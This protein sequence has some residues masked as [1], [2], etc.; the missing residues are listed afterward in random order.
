MVT[1]LLQEEDTGNEQKSSTIQRWTGAGKAN[2]PQLL[3]DRGQGSLKRKEDF[4]LKT[5][6]KGRLLVLLAE[7]LASFQQG[8]G[9]E[10]QQEN[11]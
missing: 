10:L 5:S 1:F 4:C 7:A 2:R 9:R 11:G 3:R 6:R 8:W